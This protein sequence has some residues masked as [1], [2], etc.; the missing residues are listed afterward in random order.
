[1]ILYQRRPQT[2]IASTVCTQSAP[3]S[4]RFKGLGV[5]QA[6][7]RPKHERPHGKTW[8]TYENLHN[9]EGGQ[10]IGNIGK[11]IE[12]YKKNIGSIGKL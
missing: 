7:P 9:F 5:A 4:L 1:M 8:E 6:A 2:F 3:P 10:P 11:L 12:N